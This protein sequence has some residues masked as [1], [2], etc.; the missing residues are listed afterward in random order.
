MPIKILMPALS[1][2]MTVGSLNKW[3]IKVGDKVEAG[4]ILAEIETDKAT[5]DVE[6]V[7]EG[8]ISKILVKEGET[9]IKV[10][11]P[12]A[13]I[14]SE[15]ESVVLKKENKDNIQNELSIIPNSKTELLATSRVKKK[16]SN[17]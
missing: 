1:P 14:L 12:I 17:N 13:I 9:E 7:D 2:T 11:T 4:D 3:L 10:N 8:I 15:D 16:T 5:M 6:A